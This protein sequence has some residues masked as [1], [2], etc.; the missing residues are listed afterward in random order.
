MEQNAQDIHDT[1]VRFSEYGRA[2]LL[3][4]TIVSGDDKKSVWYSDPRRIAQ[5]E[6]E[7][8]FHFSENVKNFVLDQL[9]ENRPDRIRCVYF[10]HDRQP[11]IDKVTKQISL[12]CARAK[13]ESNLFDRGSD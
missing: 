10:N 4:R 11:I 6:Q 2:S 3:F 13:N 8:D 5:V 1:L 9:K 12:N 7:C